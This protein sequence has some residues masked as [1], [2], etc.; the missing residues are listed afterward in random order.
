MLLGGRVGHIGP[1][2][3]V[4]LQNSRLHSA[5]WET[6]QIAF[7]LHR[8]LDFGLPWC[9]LVFANIPHKFTI[10]SQIFKNTQFIIVTSNQLW[11]LIFTDFIILS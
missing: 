6:E 5:D 3:N 11:S 2:I 1:N 7:K 8:Y 4:V 10:F 9:W